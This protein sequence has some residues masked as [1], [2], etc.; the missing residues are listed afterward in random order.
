[1]YITIY[2]IKGEKRIDLSHSIHSNKEVV[3]ITMLSAN[4]QYEIIKSHE[5]IDDISPAKRKLILNKTYS[6]RELISIL[7]GITTFNQIVNDDPV[8]KT[9]KLRRITKMILNLNELDNTD[10]LE[11]GRPSSA[12]V[13]YHVTAGEN[14]TWFKPK[15]PQYKKLKNGV[16]TSLTL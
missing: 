9:N 16:F 10:N 5:I 3:V 1:M 4:I 7:E 13:T 15:I 8:I 14:F 2:D 6:G 12:L 11:D